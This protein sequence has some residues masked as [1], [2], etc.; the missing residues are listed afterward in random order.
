MDPLQN[1]I[2]KFAPEPVNDP[3]DPNPVDHNPVDNPPPADEK[4][5]PPADFNKYSFLS[6]TLGATFASDE[7][8]ETFKTS[9]TQRDER[10]RDFETRQQAWEKEKEE[11][12]AS[13]DPK[14]WF[15]SDQMFVLNGLLKK[16]P[17]K[18]PLVISEI[19]AR[20][21]GESDL[22]NPVEVLALDLMLNHPK[23]YKT[24]EDAIE[25]VL[26]KYEVDDE[27][28]IDPK[29]L[30][31]MQVDATEKI[32][33]FTELK[34]QVEQPKAVS[35]SEERKNK[36]E[37]EN[38]RKEAMMAATEPLF[39]KVIPSSLKEIEFS[40]MTK[41]DKGEDV[42]EVV[43]KYEIGEGFAKSKMAQGIIENFRNTAIREGNEWTK[44]KEEKFKAETTGLLKALYLYNNLPAITSA[45][46]D[47]AYTQFADDEFKK[48]SK[49]RPLRVDGTNGK[50][51]KKEA[52]T[53]KKQNEHLKSLGIT[54]QV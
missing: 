20:E 6:E 39:T 22:S 53:S 43:F 25:D 46:I 10:L 30:R 45:F 52:E 5:Q 40:V 8:I 16:F 4:P 27:K 12:E 23:I 9:I 54:M 7:D 44:E 31:M 47:H 32:K 19:S 26:R 21:F 41:N 2:D 37:A 38:K 35:L 49:V 1:I 51:D 17:D 42:P 13:V 3:V 36:I 15:A 14:S 24:K 11:L 18:N 33:A 48:G 28:N 34:S 50:G 29:D